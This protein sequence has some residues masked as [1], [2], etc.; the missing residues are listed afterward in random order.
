MKNLKKLLVEEGLAPIEELELF[1]PRQERADPL[2]EKRKGHQ[3]R[4]L[5]VHTQALRAEPA[6]QITGSIDIHP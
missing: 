4:G 3:V 6:S 5:L 1:Q 2:L